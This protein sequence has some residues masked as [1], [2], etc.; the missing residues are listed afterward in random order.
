MIDRGDIPSGYRSLQQYLGVVTV[1]V[2]VSMN[3]K[4]SDP[5]FPVLKRLGGVVN[6]VEL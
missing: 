1:Q 6:E 3:I 2:T 5:D 4:S